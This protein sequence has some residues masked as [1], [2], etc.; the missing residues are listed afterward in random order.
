M[1]I[2]HIKLFRHLDRTECTHGKESHSPENDGG[3]EAPVHAFSRYQQPDCLLVL[4][5]S[6]P[7]D[8]T[9]GAAGGLQTLASLH[10][11][12]VERK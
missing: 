1:F 12:P 2:L 10:K 9:Q 3:D 7:C 6:A 8:F 4:R 11:S 5:R